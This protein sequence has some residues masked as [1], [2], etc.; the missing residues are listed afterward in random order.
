MESVLRATAV[1]VFVLVVFRISGKRALS[2]ITTFDFVLLLI[3]G[4]STQQ[5]LLGNDFSIINAWVVIATLL[6][7]DYALS[8][9]KN[10]W[11]VID[12]VLESRPLLIVNEGRFLEERASKEGVDLDDVL[13]AGRTS[14]G[15]ASLDEIRF[16]V[17]ERSGGISV[18]PVSG[19]RVR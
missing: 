6:L 4:E 9:V 12:P 18:I 15:L 13:A 7:L 11:P 3:I 16:A 10:H 1:Y 17:L 5:A 8:V 19:P 2:Q 14:H